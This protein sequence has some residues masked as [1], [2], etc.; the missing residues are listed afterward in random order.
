MFV[1]YAITYVRPTCALELKYGSLDLGSL[2]PPN[3]TRPNAP[4]RTRDQWN[5]SHI[6]RGRHLFT[7]AL[8]SL[9]REWA[10]RANLLCLATSEPKAHSST[11]ART[12]E[13]ALKYTHVRTPSHIRTHIHHT[14]TVVPVGRQDGRTHV[15]TG[16][17]AV[18]RAG[19]GRASART[20]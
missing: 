10:E 5:L 15:R 3:W 19:G 7:Y 2:S 9:T 14:P 4:D 12:P 20:A 13:R 8:A 6:W 11:H 1:T 18:T 16:Q 17:W